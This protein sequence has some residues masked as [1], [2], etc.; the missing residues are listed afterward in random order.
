MFTSLLSLTSFDLVANLTLTGDGLVFENGRLVSGTIHTIELGSWRETVWGTMVGLNMSATEFQQLY[1]LALAGDIE[2]LVEGVGSLVTEYTGTDA[3]DNFRNTNEY[4]IVSVDMGTG[5]DTYRHMYGGRAE[6]DIVIDGGDGRD[7]FQIS[8]FGGVQLNLRSGEMIDAAGAT[9]TVL[10]FE[11]VI[12]G[13][14]DDAIILAHGLDGSVD[15]GRGNDTLAGGDGDDFLRGGQGDDI[16]FAGE[17]ADLI[18]GGATDFVRLTSAFTYS[19]EFGA[20]NAS[21]DVQVGTG[22]ILNLEGYQGFEAVIQGAGIVQLG[23]RSE[24]LFLHDAFGDFHDRLELTPD[25]QGM[26]SIARLSSI[27]TILAEDG[28]DIIDLTSP[29]Y[30]L[31]GQEITIDGGNGN[32]VIWGSDADEVILGN[33]GDDTLFGGAG[34][35]ELT[36]GAGSDT[37]E[38]TRSS[39]SDTLLDFDA[40]EGDLL[41]FYDA[42]GAVFDEASATLTASGLSIRFTDALTGTEGQLDIA[43]GT[44]SLASLSALADLASVIDIA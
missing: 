41:L 11:A 24:A 29:D 19:A 38:F 20:R 35:N 30:S 15:G 37:F 17:G 34:A 1:D 28:H 16:F 8:G 39:T 25:Y 3:D 18:I 2:P 43:L 13:S 23:N 21:S 9:H 22:V 36:G 32:D 5:D 10:N 33:T 4:S 26:D 40:R 42:G 6:R 12:G 44:E 7:V 27:D 31:A 14:A